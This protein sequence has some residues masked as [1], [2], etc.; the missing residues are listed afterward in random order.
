M[1]GVVAVVLVV[2]EGG[3]YW[4]LA[5]AADVAAVALLLVLPPELQH[6]ALNLH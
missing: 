6:V 5:M 2:A 1:V 3:G 4:H